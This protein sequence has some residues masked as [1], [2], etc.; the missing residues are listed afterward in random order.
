MTVDAGK[1]F[2]TMKKTTRLKELINAPEILVMYPAHDALSA[3]IAERAGAKAVTVG[4]FAASGV[5]L[6]Q[7]DSSQLT[8][9]EL[10]KFYEGICASVDIPVFVDADTGFGGVT[11]VIRTVKDFER[12]GVAGLFI[13]DQRFPKRCGHTA[14]KD[15]IPSEEMVPKLRA[16]LDSRTDEDFVIMGRT[17]A[18]AV[19][20]IDD[21]IARAKLF[22]ETGC[23]VVFVEAPETTEQMRRICEEVHGPVLANMVEFGRSP[24]LDSGQLQELG[25]AVAVWPVAS[26]FVVSRALE[27]LYRTL[28]ETGSTTSLYDQMVDFEEYMEIVGLSELRDRE[29]RYERG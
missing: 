12:A 15:I 25:F 2:E 22:L 6:G 19:L 10:A 18:L 28:Q 4:G 24:L 26:V 27:V 3:R 23:D 29:A 11:N 5:L 13:E 7:P 16:A 20:G 14:G 1:P 21:A 8:A 17:D 9:T